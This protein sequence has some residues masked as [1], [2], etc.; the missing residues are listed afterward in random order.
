MTLNDIRICFNRALA[1]TFCRKKLLSVFTVLLLC[2]ILVVFSRGLALQAGQW[3]T[4]S[5]TFLPIFLCAGVLLSTGIIL[6]RVYHDEIKKKAVSYR[7][8]VNNSWS[9][10]LGASY[11]SIPIILSYLL[12]WMLLGVF[13][14]LN[15]I[16]GIGEFFGVILAFAPFL[17]NLGAI[18]LCVLSMA[19]LFYIT[20]AVALKGLNSSQISQIIIKRFQYD[21]FLNL[22]LACIAALPLAFILGLLVTAALLTGAVCYNC[23]DAVHIVLQWF[24]MMIPFT[25]LLAPAVVFFFNFAAESHVLFQKRLAPAR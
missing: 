7:Q 12:L 5:L 17:L 2:G 23:D 14:L 18:V 6:I 25:A 1:L 11:I 8:V 20:P 15:S 10:V 24:F 19:M 13:F 16:P 4:L 3:I 9:V 21:V 22:L